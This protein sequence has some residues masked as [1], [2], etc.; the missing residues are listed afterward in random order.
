MAVFAKFR[1]FHLAALLPILIFS[2]KGTMSRDFLLLVFFMNQF[3]QA[4]DY[5]KGPFRIFSKIH[6]DIPS[7]RF[8]SGVVDTSGK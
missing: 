3:P 8:A 4:P 6:G 1:E 5:S 2:L 7:S